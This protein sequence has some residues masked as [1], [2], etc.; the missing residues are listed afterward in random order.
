M[1]LLKFTPSAMDAE[2][3]EAITVQREPLI[4]GLVDSALDIEG[5]NRH[6][7]LVGPRGI[8]KSHVL[9][10]VAERIRTAAEDDS[11]VLAILDE[12]PWAT[13]SYTKFFAAI[14]GAIAHP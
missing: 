12:D 7:L 6:H 1:P 8:G 10:I 11:L 2:F 9:T 14:L 5:G 3:L 13:R 4:Q